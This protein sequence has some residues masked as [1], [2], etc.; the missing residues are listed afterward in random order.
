[1]PASRSTLIFC[2]TIE[3]M[4]NDKKNYITISRGLRGYF[5]T[6]V[7]WNPDGF[8]EPWTTS[9]LSFSTV[10]DAAVDGVK[11]AASEGLKFVPR[12]WDSE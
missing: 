6:M 12:T 1:M 10:E 9:E 2:W 11:W 7:W 8:W 4:D 3:T 5:A